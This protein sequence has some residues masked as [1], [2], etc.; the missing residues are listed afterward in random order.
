ML[1]IQIVLS[2]SSML[3][4]NCILNQVCKKDLSTTDHV[5]R[6]NII[7]YAVCIVLFSILAITGGL[8]Y[9]TLGMGVLFGVVT[10]LSNLYKMLALSSGPMHLTLLI[11]TASTILPTMS[12]VFFGERFSLPKLFFVI[13]LLFFIYLTLGKSEDLRRSKLWLLYCALAFVLQGSI[14][15]LQKIH[16]TSSHKNETGGFLLVAFICSLVYSRIRAK[17]S[18]SELKFTKRSV[19]FA[20]I[21][22]LCVFGMNY[23]N[24]KLSGIL[25]SQLFFPLV[26]GTTIV[27][28]S[29]ASYL[30]F[31]EN[32]SKRQIVGLLG[33]IASLIFICLVP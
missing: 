25:P 10:A 2:I 19:F 7:S 8:S 12:G 5:Y 30:F 16:Q 31:H 4:H 21:C 3:L 32:L 33:G 14:G 18:F 11:T 23:L 27:L 17:K 6:F 9:F 20:F 24:L 1:V 28:S 15:I 22:G 13:V 29:L 26:N